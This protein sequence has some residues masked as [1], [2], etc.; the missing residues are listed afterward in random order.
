MATRVY[1]ERSRRS[2]DA[3]L[4]ALE[5]AMARHE[6]KWGTGPHRPLPTTPPSAPQ[7]RAAPRNAGV[8]PP[9]APRRSAPRSAGVPPPPAAVEKFLVNLKKELAAGR[10]EAHAVADILNDVTRAAAARAATE[11]A[12]ATHA[13]A[14]QRARTWWEDTWASYE[15]D[16]A[17]YDAM[18]VL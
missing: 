11:Q 17:K 5:E 13:A 4:R 15:T 6:R 18:A 14:L 10:L 2:R 1:V 9:P 12:E 8:A 16:A 3:E 7:R